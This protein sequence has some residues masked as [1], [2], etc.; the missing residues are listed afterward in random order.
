MAEEKWSVPV[1]RFRPDEPIADTEICFLQKGDIFW[2]EK[3]GV[4]ERLP[5]DA[6]KLARSKAIYLVA[7]TGPIW[8]R[9]GRNKKRFAGI[10]FRAATETE[11]RLVNFTISGAL[12]NN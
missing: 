7:V 4:P 5:E 2:Y 12:I 9:L 8:A 6:M 11:I 3:N 10:K 1:K